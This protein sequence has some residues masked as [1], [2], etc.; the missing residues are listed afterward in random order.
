LHEAEAQQLENISPSPEIEGNANRRTGEFS[1]QTP[2]GSIN[3]GFGVAVTVV[4]VLHAGTSFC[5]KQH[6]AK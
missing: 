5:L 3:A 1:R 2:K 4:R 6:C